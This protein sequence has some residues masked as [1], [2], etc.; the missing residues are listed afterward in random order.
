[1]M[2]GVPARTLEG[3]SIMLQKVRDNA[4]PH[5]G[6]GMALGPERT[7]SWLEKNHPNVRRQ[8]RHV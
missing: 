3:V 8:S 1:M 2:E 5:K 4:H 6:K 7:S